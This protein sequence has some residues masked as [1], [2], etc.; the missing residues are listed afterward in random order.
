[1]T[2]NSSME[3]RMYRYDTSK[4]STL[5]TEELRN[6]YDILKLSSLKTEKLH[7]ESYIQV[8]SILA[9]F[10]RDQSLLKASLPPP[11]TI[12]IKY[13]PVFFDKN[14]GTSCS[15]SFKEEEEQQ[16]KS[17]ESSKSSLGEIILVALLIIGAVK[18]KHYLCGKPLV[19]QK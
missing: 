7:R 14:L 8:H 3:I 10:E 15:G 2:F 17:P 16:P 12:P 13:T 5:K 6:R 18:F 4:F 1:M 11:E 9:S 19:Q